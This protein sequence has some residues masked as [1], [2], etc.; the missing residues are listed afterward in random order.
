MAEIKVA[1]HNT[2]TMTTRAL[3]PSHPPPARGHP[4]ALVQVHS[5]LLSR[6]KPEHSA[7]VTPYNSG[8][9]RQAN[10]GTSQKQKHRD[11]T[12]MLQGRHHH[13]DRSHDE[14]PLVVTVPGQLVERAQAVARQRWLASV[15]GR[16]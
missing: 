6:R 15:G 2:V 9:D 7:V 1:Y 3:S 10:V 13:H 16:A 8:V 12:E 4:P 11:P 5:D 14:R